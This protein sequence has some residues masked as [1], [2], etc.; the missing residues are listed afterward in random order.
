MMATLAV[1][2]GANWVTA[3]IAQDLSVVSGPLLVVISFWSLDFGLWTLVFGLWSLCL[4]L[5]VGHF[6]R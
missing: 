6:Q 2:F 4:V 5:V 3:G 1:C